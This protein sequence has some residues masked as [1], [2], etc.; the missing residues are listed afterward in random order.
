M[1]PRAVSG[2]QIHL[3]RSFNVKNELG[4]VRFLKLCQLALGK[5]GKHKCRE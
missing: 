5:G 3:T 4:D 2:K 1:K